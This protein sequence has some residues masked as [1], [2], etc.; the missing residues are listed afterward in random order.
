MRGNVG[1]QCR[2]LMRAAWPVVLG[3]TL[4]APAAAADRVPATVPAGS[5]EL[6]DGISVVSAVSGLDVLRAKTS[7]RRRGSRFA[8]DLLGDAGE[9]IQS[10]TGTVRNG[11]VV[12]RRIVH[13]SDVGEEPLEG[14]WAITRI[15]P[16]RSQS[17]VLRNEWAVVV[18]TRSTLI[19]RSRAVPLRPAPAVPGTS[20]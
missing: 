18:M 16:Y 17:V 5:A 3:A 12:A 20:P 14:T 8:A 1:R 6:W 15:G 4:W 7:V 9:P 11:R 19:E 2:A 13:R 10:I